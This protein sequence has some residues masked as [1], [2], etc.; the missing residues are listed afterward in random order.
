MVGVVILG[1]LSLWLLPSLL[2]D[3]SPQGTA[4][5]G[6]RGRVVALLGVLGV[7]GGLVFT[8]MSFRLSSRTQAETN[9]HAMENL[10]NATQAFELTRRGQI[11]DRYAKAV[12]MLGDPSPEICV[13]G[14]YALEHILRDDPDHERAVVSTLSAFVR[15]HAKLDDGTP[16]SPPWPPDE[17]ERD[18]TKPS[19]RVQ[20]ALNVLSERTT[21][22]GIA[23]DL[24]DCDL[25]G[26]RL[27]NARL[28]NA[29]FRRSYLHKAKLHDADLR[30]A[31]L[32]RADLTGASLRGA[33]LTDAGVAGAKFTE[34]SLSREQI[35]SVRNADA[36]DWQEKPRVPDEQAS[37]IAE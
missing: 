14:I 28:A 33:D 1:G 19:F 6:V 36:I 12:E 10:R 13:G 9:R 7:L 11:T 21:S 24:R 15:R 3:R 29:S 20:A 17:A 4:E 18:A 37:E 27:S 26:A 25:R 34:G 31:A 2:A 5:D 30:G 23:P 16:P 22:G 35:D 8:G 32:R